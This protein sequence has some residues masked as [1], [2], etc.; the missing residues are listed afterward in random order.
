MNEVSSCS[1]IKIKPLLGTNIQKLSDK[2]NGTEQMA[3]GRKKNVLMNC[4][5]K[6]LFIL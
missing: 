2:M 6:I 1:H 5:F 4:R 3:R